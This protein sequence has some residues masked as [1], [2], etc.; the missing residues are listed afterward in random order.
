MKFKS[1]YNRDTCIPMLLAALFMITEIRNQRKCSSID[2]WM[3][4]S[5]PYIHNAVLFSHKSQQNYIIG[6]N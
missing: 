2:E 6:W 3:E 5:V 4:A 1:A